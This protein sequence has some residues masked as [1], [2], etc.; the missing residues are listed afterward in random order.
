MLTPDVSGR[1]PRTGLHCTSWGALELRKHGTPGLT[2]QTKGTRKNNLSALNAAVSARCLVCQLH[3]PLWHH[4]VWPR[5]ATVPVPAGTHHVY[6]A[7]MA[8]TT[9][10]HVA[11]KQNSTATWPR[12]CKCSRRSE[13]RMLQ[14]LLHKKQSQP[15]SSQSTPKPSFRLSTSRHC[16]AALCHAPASRYPN[17]IGSPKAS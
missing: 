1:M 9:L 6:H 8:Q 7:G 10:H 11:V 17:S 12:T 14:G 5:G 13:R 4:H 15:P 2:G 16:E 3:E